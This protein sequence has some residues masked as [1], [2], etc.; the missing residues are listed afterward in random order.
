MTAGRKRHEEPEEHENH[1]RWLVTYADMVTLLMVLF[2]VMFAMSQVDERKFYELR[3]GLAAGFGS[4]DSILNGRPALEEGPG[5]TATGTI[6]PQ[7]DLAEAPTEVREAVEQAVDKSEQLRK[8]RA[9]AEIAAEADRL[10]EVRE[11]LMKALKDQGLEDD[12]RAGL[13]DR[14]LVV[15][16]VSKHVVFEANLASLSARGQE[17]V[18]TLAPVLA[19][20]PDNLEI[21]GHTNQV[22]VKPKYYDTDWDLSAARALTVLRRLNERHGLAADRLS[23]AAFGNSRP[24]VPPQREGSQKV[25][26]RVDIVVLT[27]LPQGP[28]ADLPD[29]LARKEARDRTEG[30]TGRDSDPDSGRGTDKEPG[31]GALHAADDVTP[32]PPTV[33]PSPPGEQR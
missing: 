4:G 21:D 22:Q 10:G 30:R 27:S 33:P 15:S 17:V 29:V 23:L 19:S 26:K 3:S 16:L 1:E 7:L 2:I 5:T 12:V 14:G 20:L 11:R 31:D 25:N 13:S 8:E 6:A 9:A 24:L 28:A 18:D 32:D